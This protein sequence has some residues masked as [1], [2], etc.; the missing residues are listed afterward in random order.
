MRSLFDSPMCQELPMCATYCGSL[1][2][3]RHGVMPIKLMSK[4]KSC[5]Y[6]L[7]GEDEISITTMFHFF[8]LGYCL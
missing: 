4:S 7:H 2:A 5:A 3:P 6:C 8:C 1:E